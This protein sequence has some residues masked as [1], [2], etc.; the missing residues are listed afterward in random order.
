MAISSLRRTI[1]L[2]L[3]EIVPAS[4]L[5][6]LAVPPLP[7]DVIETLAKRPGAQVTIASPESPEAGAGAPYDCIFFFEPA[8]AEGAAAVCEALLDGDGLLVLPVKR[9]EGGEAADDTAVQAAM[10]G[11]GLCSYVSYENSLAPEEGY[12]LESRGQVFRRIGAWVKTEYDPFS[13]AKRLGESGRPDWAFEVLRLA[14][15]GAVSDPQN[16]AAVTL[17]KQRFLEAQFDAADTMGRLGLLWKAQDEAHYVPGPAFR[18]LGEAYARQAVMWAKL[19]A[20]G[21][22]A[23]ILRD[24]DAAG[25]QYPDGIAAEVARARAMRIAAG[26]QPGAGVELPAEWRGGERL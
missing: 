15:L 24:L 25:A 3:E 26:S 4:A 6:V 19:G 1:L 9:G 17:E 21:H 22:A 7:P 12:R 8:Q 14:P 13:H 2:S 20:A 11:A 23:K 16:A 10:E 5:R 18:Y